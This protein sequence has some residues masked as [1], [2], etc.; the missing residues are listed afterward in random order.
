MPKV[1]CTRGSELFIQET[2]FPNSR[3]RGEGALVGPIEKVGRTT[4]SEGD[5]KRGQ[6]MQTGR[7]ISRIATYDVEFG[8][9]FLQRE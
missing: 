4:Q 5:T 9:K 1:P 6:V 3:R 7:A 2:V 8:W